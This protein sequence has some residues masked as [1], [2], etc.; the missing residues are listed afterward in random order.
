MIL[1]WEFHC[2]FKMYFFFKYLQ[3]MKKKNLAISKTLRG[4]EVK[5]ETKNDR[6]CFQ[7]YFFFRSHF[8]CWM[9]EWNTYFESTGTCT[10]HGS[11]TAH[12]YKSESSPLQMNELCKWAELFLSQT[13][14]IQGAAIRGKAK[15]LCFPEAYTHLTEMKSEHGRLQ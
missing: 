7:I 5:L 2:C 8:F 1:V 13:L 10:A 6:C 12:Q 4:T 3:Y 15:I 9:K 14:T 11:L